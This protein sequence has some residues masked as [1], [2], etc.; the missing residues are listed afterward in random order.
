MSKTNK[1]TK[2]QPAPDK[3][4]RLD[5]PAGRPGW[6]QI[7][8]GHES[9]P[10]YKW[11]LDDSATVKLAKPARIVVV[12]NGGVLDSVYSNDRQLTVELVD[13]DDL[14]AEGKWRDEREAI[15]S[16]A[17]DGLFSIY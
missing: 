11:V 14:E 12:I 15:E 5:K 13:H 16:E 1:Q 10:K 3:P 6:K 7:P 4:A 8:S 9:G 17:T 2:G